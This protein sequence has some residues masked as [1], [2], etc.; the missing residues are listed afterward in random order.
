MVID[1]L[2]KVARVSK[3]HG[4]DGTLKLHSYM[5]DISEIL[6]KSVIINDLNYKLESIAGLVS[7]NPLVKLV[8]I[9]SHE[10]ALSL[11]DQTIYIHRSNLPPLSE[12]EYYWCD[13]LDCIVHSGETTLGTVIEVRDDGGGLL[14]KLN[15]NEYI[16]FDWIDRIEQNQIFLKEEI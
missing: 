16:L 3:P 8:G 4:F 11:K 14:L 5:E 7:K 12:G 15:N 6:G 10:K 2:C 1:K 13:L 9:D